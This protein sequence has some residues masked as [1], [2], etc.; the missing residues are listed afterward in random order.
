MTRWSLRDYRGRKLVAHNGGLSGFVSRTALIPDIQG[1]V[2][3]L[4]DSATATLTKAGYLPYGKSANAPA[5]F[6]HPGQRVQAIEPVGI[7][8][9]VAPVVHRERLPG[10]GFGLRIL[11]S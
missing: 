2:I 9:L 6:G 7:R 1:S 11:P 5:A 8:R 4:L 3:G 10:Q